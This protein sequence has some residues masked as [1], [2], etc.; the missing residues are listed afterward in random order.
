MSI[1]TKAQIIEK[2]GKPIFAVIPYEDYLALLP[3]KNDE[4]IPHE[5]TG[6]VIKKKMVTIQRKKAKRSKKRLDRVF[7]KKSKT[8]IHVKCFVYFGQ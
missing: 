1:L 7:L 3:E 6:L 4:T 2:N 8:H 5:V